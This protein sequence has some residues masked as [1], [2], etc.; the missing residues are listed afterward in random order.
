MEMK[1]EIKLKE[2]E[3]EKKR[4]D[5]QKELIELVKEFIKGTLHNIV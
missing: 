2:L 3:N 4:L 5:N 1:D